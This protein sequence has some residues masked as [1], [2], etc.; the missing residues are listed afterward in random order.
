MALLSLI[1]IDHAAAA[2]TPDQDLKE[3]I[4][5]Y[6]RGDFPSAIRLVKPLLYP[7]ISLTNQ[8]QVIEAYRLLGISCLFEK[9]KTQAE[10]QFLAI[11]SLRPDFAFDPLVDPPVAVNLL[12]EIKRR[13]AEKIE[14]IRN[15]ERNEVALRRI[16]DQRREE[17]ARRRAIQVKV[18]PRIILRT[19]VEHSYWINF[20][21]FGAGQFQNGHLRKGYLLL[22]AEVAL[23]ALSLVTALDL[24]LSYPNGR[25]PESKRDSADALVITQVTS[26]ALF[27]GLAVYGV[28]DALIYYQPQTVL[29]RPEPLLRRTSLFT[30]LI[31]PDAAGLGFRL[32]Y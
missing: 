20:L 26:G 17:E 29:E 11:L 9:D 18:P 1:L 23:G 28:I 27:L 6:D 30:P 7:Q 3:A 19:V 25:V 8:S 10:K 4:R 16:A 31:G 2:A 12:E 13:N 24:R 5:A 21:P 15:R 22:G 14:A 32:F